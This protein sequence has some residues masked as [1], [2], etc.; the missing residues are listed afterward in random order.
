[1]ALIEL[2]LNPS[3]R[4]LRLFGLVWFPLVFAVI[5]A[6]VLFRTGSLPVAAAIWGGGL[7]V[8]V[9]GLLVPAFLRLVY[10][11][12]LHAVYPIGWAVSS[13]LLATIYYLVITPMGL[14]LR[15][16]GRDALKLRRDRSA[17]SHW[18][19]YEPPESAE[20]YFEQS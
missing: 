18:V 1:V 5:G 8:S 11:G 17:R 6:L 3:K 9:V 7:A 20:R 15:A 4:D 14:A 12:V 19:P 16:V 13:L 2:D 10:L